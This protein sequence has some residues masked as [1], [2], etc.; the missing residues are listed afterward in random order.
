MTYKSGHRAYVFG[1]ERVKYVHA[2]VAACV[3]LVPNRGLA[4]RQASVSIIQCARASLLT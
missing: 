1:R 3:S 4:P 2:D